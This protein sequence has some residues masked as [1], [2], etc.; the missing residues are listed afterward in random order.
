VVEEDLLVEDEVFEVLLLEEIDDDE[1]TLPLGNVD[2][3][4]PTLILE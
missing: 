4:V 1:V 3:I 2:P